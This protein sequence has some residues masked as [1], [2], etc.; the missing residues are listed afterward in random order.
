MHRTL[1][2]L[3]LG[4]ASARIEAAQNRLINDSLSGVRPQ[5]ERR[6]D[7]RGGA[8]LDEARQALARG[9]EAG[10]APAVQQARGMF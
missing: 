4:A 8:R 3:A 7:A 9:D 5:G 1:A 10:T 2:T 6:R